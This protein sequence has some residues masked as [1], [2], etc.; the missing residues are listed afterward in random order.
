MGKKTSQKFITL[1]SVIM[2]VI[3]IVYVALM[4]V[5]INKHDYAE[6]QSSSEFINAINS[7]N[8]KLN[9]ESYDIKDVKCVSGGKEIDLKALKGSD[10]EIKQTLIDEMGYKLIST[11]KDKRGSTTY[12]ITADSDPSFDVEWTAYNSP[13]KLIWFPQHPTAKDFISEMKSKY[14]RAQDVE[15]DIN[16][17]VLFPVLMFVLGIA[18]AVLVVV[19]SKR[20]FFLIFPFAFIVTG[21]I[22][23]I[24]GFIG[25]TTPQMFIYSIFK[26]M[27]STVFTVQFMVVIL[28]IIAFAASVYFRIQHH[29]AVKAEEVAYYAQNA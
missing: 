20:G 21:L 12:N 25:S 5:T 8:V 26:D 13:A 23:H 14:Y 27:N 10:N 15:Y 19:F 22:A 6:T 4:F 17:V 3:M 16:D 11:D 2:A 9:N 7:G 29:K 18:G 28:T 1:T 24:N